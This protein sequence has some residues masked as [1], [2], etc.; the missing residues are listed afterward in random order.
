MSLSYFHGSKIQSYRSVS[1]IF[2]DD[3]I[4]T[5]KTARKEIVLE[6]DVT[7]SVQCLNL[8]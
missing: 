5:I 4:S 6:F 1:F 3:D 7:G 2:D 8:C